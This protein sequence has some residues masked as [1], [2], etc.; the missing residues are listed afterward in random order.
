MLM[1]GVDDSFLCFF[2]VFHVSTGTQSMNSSN[3]KKLAHV[4]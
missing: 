3:T 1:T 4:Q 2:L